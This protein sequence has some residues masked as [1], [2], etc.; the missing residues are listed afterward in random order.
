MSLAPA[1]LPEPSPVTLVASDAPYSPDGSLA[2]LLSFQTANHDLWTLT[3]DRLPPPGLPPR[4]YSTHLNSPLF[5]S[6]HYT[7]G[8]LLFCPGSP[9]VRRQPPS[10]FPHSTTL[11]GQGGSHT[12]CC[13]SISGLCPP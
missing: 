3:L 13:G 9:G 12:R 2:P 6:P 11:P 1:N 5:T 4:L 8:P 7:S 10:R